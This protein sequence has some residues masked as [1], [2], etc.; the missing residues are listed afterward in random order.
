MIKIQDFA[1]ECGVTDRQI[2]RQLKKYEAELEGLYERRGQ[3]GTW[4]SEEACEIIRS[5]MR[6]QPIAVGDGKVAR[7]NEELQARVKKL[8]QLLATKEIL[9]DNAQARVAAL[10]DSAT[11]IA[12]LEANN[13]ELERRAEQ[14]EQA[15][16][17][18]AADRQK[19]EEAVK[20]ALRK[21]ADLDKLLGK[22]QEERDAAEAKL[23]AYE[24]LPRWKRL[25]WKG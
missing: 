15:A 1:R 9:L 11:K 4:L 5:K 23:A 10:Q 13:G 25:F 19:A 6:E 17:E 2:Q 24:A 14:A 22:V 7:E 20:D 18:Q 8:E 21:A 16:A 3:N 12:L